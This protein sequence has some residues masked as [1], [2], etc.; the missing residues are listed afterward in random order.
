MRPSGED[1][2]SRTRDSGQAVG[3]AE[4][5]PSSIVEQSS[6]A[7]CAYVLYTVYS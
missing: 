6:Q 7:H 3:C 5:V 4:I 2:S 1:S